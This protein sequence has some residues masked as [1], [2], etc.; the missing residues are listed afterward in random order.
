ML[1]AK[2][3][4]LILLISLI[5]TARAYD[6]YSSEAQIPEPLL[7]DLVR[8]INSDKGEWEFNSL[9]VDGNGSDIK[10]VHIAP[11]IE[12]A[13]ADGK[14]V[15]FELPTAEG[16]IQTLKSALQ[17][18]IPSW[19]VQLAGIQ[20]IYETSVKE[21]LHELTPLLILAHRLSPRWSTLAMV[22]NQ[23]SSAAGRIHQK[24]IMN[25][26]FFYNESEA[27]DLGLEINLSGLGA[28]FDGLIMMPQVHTL[29]SGDIKIQAGLGT[30]YDGYRHS[31]IS[32]FRLIK[33]FNEGRK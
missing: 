4:L 22:G 16:K 9:L 7:F 1:N 13:F 29:L 28:S 27:I 12:W 11:E 15:E 20:V 10:N 21:N 25:L 30:L 18:Q 33:E 23:I 8:R 2:L 26:N 14:A 6:K 31:A 19:F 24:P 3:L 5:N 17:F 32:A